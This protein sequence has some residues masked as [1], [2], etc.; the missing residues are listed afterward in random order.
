MAATTERADLRP[1]S[2]PDDAGNVKLLIQTFLRHQ[3]GHWHAVARDYSVVGRGRS[4]DEA[5]EN[6]LEMLDDYFRACGDDGLSLDQVRRPIPLRWYL[7]LRAHWFMGLFARLLRRAGPR[8]IE[9]MVPRGGVGRY[10]C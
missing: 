5:V 10:A 2:E 6:M 7:E 9:I 4:P 1:D 8:D 3:D